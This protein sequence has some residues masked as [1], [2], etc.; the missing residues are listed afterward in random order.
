[1]P[2]SSLIRSCIFGLLISASAISAAFFIEMA[3]RPALPAAESGRMSATLICPAPSVLGAC[4]GPACCTGVPKSPM[5]EPV[6]PASTPAS[7]ATRIPI[8]RRLA[9]EGGRITACDIRDMADL[10]DDE[11]QTSAPGHDGNRGILSTKS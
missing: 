3:A 9:G 11:I 1:L 8:Q 2:P 6:Q 5:P 7:P 4:G 10:L